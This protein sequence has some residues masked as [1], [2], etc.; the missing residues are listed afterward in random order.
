MWLYEQASISIFAFIFH[1][2]KKHTMKTLPSKALCLCLFSLIS[3]ALLANHFVANNL[4]ENIDPK[5]YWVIET[6]AKKKDAIVRYY[7]M[8][9][10][11]VHIEKIPAKQV[12][13]K[14]KNTIKK[15]N[16]KASVF[17]GMHKKLENQQ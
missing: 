16:E 10:Q 8:Q 12:N 15:L 6:Q 5:G 3:S 14:R 13:L 11:L 2:Q 9:K 4:P 7:T 1:T 17:A